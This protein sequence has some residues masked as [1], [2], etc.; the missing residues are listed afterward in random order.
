MP[1]NRGLWRGRA[2][3][4]IAVS[5]TVEPAE[6]MPADWYELGA[7]APWPDAVNRSQSQSQSQRGGNGSSQV[8]RQGQGG[9]MTFQG[10]REG[11][12]HQQS[13]QQQ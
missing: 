6:R 7:Q 3:E 11:Y 9:G 5:V 4:T 2:E 13:Q 12:R 8:Q 10:S 1:P